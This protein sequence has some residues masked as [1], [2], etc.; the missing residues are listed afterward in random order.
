[1]VDDKGKCVVG[2]LSHES[3]IDVLIEVVNNFVEVGNDLVQAS[4][5]PNHI[6]PN[7]LRLNGFDQTH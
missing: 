6:C 3:A 7:Q 2:L 4:I 1:M 5:E